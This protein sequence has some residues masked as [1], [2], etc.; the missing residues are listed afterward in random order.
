[1]N[2]VVLL[3]KQDVTPLQ[4]SNVER[5]FGRGGMRPIMRQLS[6]VRAHRPLEGDDA[7]SQSRVAGEHQGAR[8]GDPLDLHRVAEEAIQALISRGRNGVVVMHLETLRR[9][10][11]SRQAQRLRLVEK[12]MEHGRVCVGVQEHAERQRQRRQLARDEHRHANPRGRDRHVVRQMHPGRGHLP[13]LRE[14]VAACVL[15]LAPRS[16]GEHQASQAEKPD[17]AFAEC[18]PRPK[19]SRRRQEAA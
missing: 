13:R 17:A 9:V 12:R 2:T 1:M 4:N 7:Q 14:A 16:Q 18:W 11:Q 15:P 8:A 19:P 3:W 5:P 6:S 10:A